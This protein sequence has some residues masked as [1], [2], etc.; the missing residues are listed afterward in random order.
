[1][2]VA[3]TKAQNAGEWEAAVKENDELFPKTMCDDQFASGFLSPSLPLS[4]YLLLSFC[5]SVC[6][7]V[8]VCLAGWLSVY[9]SVCLSVRVWRRPVRLG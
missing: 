7:S 1:M 9:L 4:L 3:I 8:S 2:S 6:L 5:L